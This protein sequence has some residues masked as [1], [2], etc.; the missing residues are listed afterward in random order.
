MAATE[1]PNALASS[2]LS[3]RLSLACW[4]LSLLV[5]VG[6]AGMAAN[7]LVQGISP[8]FMGHGTMLDA[9]VEWLEVS[10][11]TRASNVSGVASHPASSADSS[12]PLLCSRTQSV[13]E[14]ALDALSAMQ[15][16]TDIAWGPAGL[17]VLAFVIAISHAAAA[18]QQ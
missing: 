11:C 10:N 1:P 13:S 14:T 15:Q 4:D 9:A 2:T 17:H 18:V 12:G 16:A 7:W 3:K 6:L 5:L 8:Y